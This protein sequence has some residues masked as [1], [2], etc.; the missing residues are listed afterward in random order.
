MASLVLEDEIAVTN[1]GSA[2]A[3]LNRNNLPS[4]IYYYKV[5]NSEVKG[6]GKIV[7]R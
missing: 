2:K 4:G 1:D 5:A 3:T 6:S 7:I